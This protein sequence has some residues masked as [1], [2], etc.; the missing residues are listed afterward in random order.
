MFTFQVITSG[1]VFWLC[2]LVSFLLTA[3]LG[4]SRCMAQRTRI[5]A[6]RGRPR[7]SAWTL[8][9]ILPS[10]CSHRCEHV[11]NE[12]VDGRAL[13]LSF[14]LTLMGKNH[15]NWGWSLSLWCLLSHSLASQPPSQ[16]HGFLALPVRDLF[17]THPYFVFVKD[18]KFHVQCTYSFL[19]QALISLSRVRKT[20]QRL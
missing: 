9:L 16:G 18:R 8:L 6:S 11:R 13:T 3:I 15:K 4:S 5:P 2:S 12:P 14:S 20:K 10:P 19:F 7:L 17:R 1:L